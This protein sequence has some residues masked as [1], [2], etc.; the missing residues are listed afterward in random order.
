MQCT[1]IYQQ[2]HG[3]ETI[4]KSMYLLFLLLLNIYSILNVIMCVHIKK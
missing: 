2:R 3:F 1:I 4:L